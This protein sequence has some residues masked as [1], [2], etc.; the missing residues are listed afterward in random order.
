L[1]QLCCQQQSPYKSNTAHVTTLQA[2]KR[3]VA[4]AWHHFLQQQP[5][6]TAGYYRGGIA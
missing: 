6:L 2:I 1:K 5:Q 4:S 3:H